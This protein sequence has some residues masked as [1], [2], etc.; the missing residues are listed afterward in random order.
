MK[1][2]I[3][4]WDQN[5]HAIVR[6]GKHKIVGI[7]DELGE[8]NGV[9]SGKFLNIP[10]NG[11]EITN[12]F[13]SLLNKGADT[14]VTTGEGLFFKHPEKAEMWRQN[15]I[16][17]INSGLNIYTM[18]K[19][20]Y[21]EKTKDIQEMAKSKGVTFTEASDP[22]AYEKYREFAELAVKEPVKVPVVCFCGTSMNSG[23]ITAMMSFKNILEKAG[24]KVGV[25]G[26]E[27]CSFFLDVEQVVPEVIPTMRG[28]HT[29]LGAVK[30]VEKEQKPGIIFVGGQTGLRASVTDVLEAR[31]GAVVAWQ[32]LLGCKPNKIVLC[33]KWKTAGKEIKPHLELIKNSV[34]RAQVTSIVIN[35]YQAGP[36]K[37]SETISAIEKETG[38]K[39]FDVLAN[40]EKAKEAALSLL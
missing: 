38:I 35:G 13:E 9:D 22:N 26:T 10:P 40:P 32:I 36:D 6:F 21:G 8:L 19:A 12:D 28:A 25:V 17:A 27:P 4:H 14:V 24:K 15:I 39:T 23:K 30:K 29:I 7:F 1:L 33:S 37:L 34:L 5:A 11:I 16:K 31:A 20:L 3:H 2:I 18:S